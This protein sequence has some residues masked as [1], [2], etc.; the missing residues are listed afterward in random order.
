MNKKSV[1]SLILFSLLICSILFVLSATFKAALGNDPSYSMNSDPNSWPMFHNDLT[2]SGYSHSTAPTTNQTLWIFSTGS[3][4]TSSPAIA[5][6]IVY[7]GSGGGVFYALSTIQGANLWNYNLGGTSV[8]SSPAVANGIVYFGAW[9]K[10]VYALNA[11]TG[12]KIW[13]YQTGNYIESSP[14][15]AEGTVYIASYDGSVYALNAT[16]GGRLWSFQT[17]SQVRSSPA[18]TQG[19][20]YI[21]SNNG[22]VYSLNAS[23]GNELWRYPVGDTANSS[24]AVVGGVVY[25]GGTTLGIGNLYAL[26]ALTGIK[27]WSYRTTGVVDSSPA[28]ANGVVYVGSVTNSGVQGFIYALNA[29]S[30]EMLWSYKASGEEFASPAVANG[31][32]YIGDD[33]GIIYALKAFDGSSLWSY[34]TD[35]S[36]GWSSPAVANGVLYATSGDGKVYAFSSGPTPTPSPTATPTPTPVLTQ[37]PMPTAISTPCPSSTPNPKP[38]QTQVSGEITSNTTW[39]ETADPYTLTGNILVGNGITLTIEAGAN[40]NLNGYYIEVNGT[41]IARG[42]DAN[43]IFFKDSYESQ[44][45]ITFDPAS[46]SWNQSTGTGSIIESAVF[47]SVG[48]FCYDAAP[49]INHNLF[50]NSGTYIHAQ[51]AILFIGP[52]SK[53][54]MIISNNTF[55]SDYAQAAIEINSAGASP[56]IIINNNFVGVNTHNI[57]SGFDT[58]DINATYNWWGTTDAQ[59][60][61]QT[62]YDYKKNFHFGKVIFVPFLISKNIL[63]PAYNSTPESTPTPTTTTTTTPTPTSSPTLLPSPSPTTPPKNTTALT[64]SCQS[65]TSYS[66][67]SVNIAGHLTSNGTGVSGA[68][69]LLSYSVNDGSSWID[70]TTTTT[71]SNGGFLATWKPQVSGSYLVKT[72]YPGSAIYA[73]TSQVVTFMVTPFQE[74]NV[75]SLTSNSTITSFFYNSTGNLLSFSTDGTSGTT[76]YVDITVPKSLAPDNVNLMVYL[77]G[78]PLTY[79][80]VDQGN[81]WLVSFIYHQSSHEVTINLGAILAAENATSPWIIIGGITPLIIAIAVFLI[82]RQRKKS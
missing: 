32:V 19:A 77:D 71:D 11:Y 62:I 20:V 68:H 1:L 69:I 67:F 28:V 38:D 46:M 35:G 51:Y 33:N 73:G 37:S 24:P 9:D 3:F 25:V 18:V 13:S 74:Q 5:G 60:I 47:D 34:Q 39:N 10:T 23:T 75:F 29:S 41:L 82:V 17:G 55:G 15:V 30:G 72:E 22:N 53:P 56:P 31:V 36:A 65:P 14:A 40:V 50:Y 61:N 70:L 49:R 57:Q 6:G 26:N 4:I 16:T 59:A 76:G 43:P 21:S 81:S 27:L 54:A 52:Y 79:S 78:T 12:A 44:E 58:P 42:T 45:G 48:I 8:T 64:V 66:I 2:H 63:A 80:T 7:V